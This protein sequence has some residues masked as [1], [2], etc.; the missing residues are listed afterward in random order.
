M[1]NIGFIIFSLLSINWFSRLIGQ[2][3]PIQNFSSSVN[4][5]YSNFPYY[6]YKN[7]SG[8]ISFNNS[9]WTIILE[10]TVVEE[11]V[12][13]QILGTDFSRLGMNGRFT[14]AYIQYNG[15]NWS[16]LLGRKKTSFDQ[17]NKGG[18]KTRRCIYRRVKFEFGAKKKATC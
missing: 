16:I 3:D 8:F 13:R 17:K 15:N 9:N 5:L 14:Q 4:I 7:I 11:S 12:G 2:D 10:P 1:F 6:N 18:F